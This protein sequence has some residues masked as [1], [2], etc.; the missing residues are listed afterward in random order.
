MVICGKAGKN[1]AE[2]GSVPPFHVPHLVPFIVELL[3]RILFHNLATCPAL[4][5][6]DLLHSVYWSV[7]KIHRKEEDSFFLSGFRAKCLSLSGLYVRKT[8]RYS[9]VLKQKAMMFFASFFKTLENKGSC[10]KYIVQAVAIICTN[11]YVF[12]S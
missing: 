10:P 8:S 4:H 9:W 6:M 12:N 11:L 3:F 1:S 2:G 5:F 7:E